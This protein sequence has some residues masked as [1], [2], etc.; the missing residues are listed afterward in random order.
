MD[1]RELEIGLRGKLGDKI[2]FAGIYTSDNIPHVTHL[3]KPIIFIVNTL[4]STSDINAVGHWVAFYVMGSPVQT[5]VFFDSYGFH[6]KMYGKEFANVIER[7]HKLPFFKT[8]SYFSMR[9]QPDLSM[10]CGLYVLFFIHYC[11]HKGLQKFLNIYQSTFSSK[12][13]QNNDLFVTKYYFKHLNKNSCRHWKRGS[14]RAITFKEC[15]EI[16]ELYI[17][18]KLIMS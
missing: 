16:G 14:N 1:V 13:L 2:N 7:Y 10:K 17:K 3:S 18:I 5:I 15:R 6:P 9:L 8:L 11:S 12:N 4:K